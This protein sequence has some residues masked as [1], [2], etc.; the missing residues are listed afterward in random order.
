M[1]KSTKYSSIGYKTGLVGRLN[2]SFFFKF[3]NYSGMNP[4]DIYFTN[5][6]IFYTYAVGTYTRERGYAAYGLFK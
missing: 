2:S 5:M 4:T 6:T 3:L 1:V